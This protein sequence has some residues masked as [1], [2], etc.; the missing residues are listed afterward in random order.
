MSISKYTK[1]GNQLIYA[2]YLGGGTNE[3]PHS[4][5]IDNDG[6]L[7][8]FGT[9]SSTNYPTTLGAIQETKRKA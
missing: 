3:F 6:Q 7:I 8:V 2:T 5:I 1:S 4:L 9:S